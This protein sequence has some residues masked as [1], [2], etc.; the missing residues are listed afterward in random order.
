MSHQPGVTR[1]SEDG[2]VAYT[3]SPTTGGIYVERNQRLP[4]TRYVLG[5]RFEDEA[6]FLDWCRHDS[7]RF[8]YPLLLAEV[9]R[10]GR[11]FFGLR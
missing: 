4:T 1:I 11:A 3:I 7:L 9:E 2:A 8:G 10:N 5:V 6:K